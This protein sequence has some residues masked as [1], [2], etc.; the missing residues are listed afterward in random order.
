[1]LL[2]KAHNKSFYF[3]YLKLLQFKNNKF[4]NKKT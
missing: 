1:M 4:F 3:L 2:E